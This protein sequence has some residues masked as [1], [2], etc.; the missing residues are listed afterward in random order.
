M[1]RS[2]IAST[3]RSR[4]ALFRRT[5]PAALW[6][7]VGAV[8][9]L[10]ALA[11]D[12]EVDISIKD[13]QFIPSEINVPAGQKIKIVVKNEGKM[14]SEFQSDDFHREK[15]VPSGKEITLYVGPLAAGSY[16]FF[17]D[18]HPDTRG[19]LVVK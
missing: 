13:H 19:H 7:A 14:P 16:E 12:P 18:F 1:P 5:L 8:V 3:G 9:A 6:L 17:D 11:E 10:P 2:T 4:A 15:V